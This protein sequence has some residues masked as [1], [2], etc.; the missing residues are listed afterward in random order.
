MNKST[1]IL[2]KTPNQSSKKHLNI[3][4]NSSSKFIPSILIASV[5]SKI[6]SHKKSSKKALKGNN[7]QAK[8]KSSPA[9]PT[10][11]F[12]QMI[13]T[14]ES[15]I[16]SSAK[17]EPIENIKFTKEFRKLDAF[18][19]FTLNNKIK[20][21]DGQNILENQNKRIVSPTTPFKIS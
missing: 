20:K 15:L 18:K 16:K 6:K 10:E 5:K 4:H 3:L 17:T 11:T 14:C 7:S 2:L 9:A 8:T 1:K 13:K 21:S 19:S 12:D